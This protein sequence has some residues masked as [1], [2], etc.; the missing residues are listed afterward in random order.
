MR[1]AKAITR[2]PALLAASLVCVVSATESS[3]WRIETVDASGSGESTSMKIDKDGNA[4][5]CYVFGRGTA[6]K[7]AFW[8]HLLNRWFVMVVDAYPNACSLALD[9]K[10][11]PHISYADYGTGDGARLHYAHWDGTSWKKAPV[12][13]NAVKIAAY[14]SIGLDAE[15]KPTI[16]Y[17]EYRGPRGTDFKIRLRSVRW[18]GKEWEVRTVDAEEGSGKANHM[19]TDPQGN[20]HLVYANV[21]VGDMRYAY[22][23]GKKWSL[24]M[25]EGRRQSG[26]H[27]VGQSCAV[28]VDREGNPHVTYMNA[29]TLQIKYAVRK[30]G[31][32]VKHQV[33]DQLT[34]ST[35]DFD[36]NSIVVDDTGRP[37][38]SYY[39]VGQGIL[40]LAHL[41]GDKWVI[42]TVDGNG[43]GFTSS[44]QIDRG[45]MWISYADFV[46]NS[47][48]VASRDMN[49]VSSNGNTVPGELSARDSRAV[50]EK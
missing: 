38:I 23:D 42:E 30:A 20:F 17:Y 19:T 46:S 49:L 48:K 39:D 41:E 14:S 8:D 27:Y 2:I 11:R 35:D 43:S 25:V 9:S 6:L 1:R 34:G 22:W 32:W 24:E 33:V 18:T 45:K 13:L 29:S 4:H 3:P 16:A 5:I 44:M 7:Y 40:K 28:T 50:Q 36:R 21:G 26:G 47:L 10:Q 31:R 37:W 15:D 12:P